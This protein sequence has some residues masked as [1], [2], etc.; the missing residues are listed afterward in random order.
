VCD[1]RPVR[2]DVLDEVVWTEVIRLLE[3]PTLIKDELERRLDAAKDAAPS[4]R[5]EETLNRELVRIQKSIERLTTAYQE[6]LLSLDELRQRLPALRQREGANRAELQSITDQ[7]ATR[8][9]YLRLAQ[10]LCHR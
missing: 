8:A 1:N 4:K 3:D 2:Q 6:D 10:T 9:A 5:R 7:I